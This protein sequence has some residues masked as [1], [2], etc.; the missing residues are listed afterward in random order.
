MGTRQQDQILEQIES[1]HMDMRV[2]NVIHKV[3]GNV[4]ESKVESRE[5]LGE[6]GKIRKIK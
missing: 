5:R 2:I 3:G 1:Q 6:I 4:R